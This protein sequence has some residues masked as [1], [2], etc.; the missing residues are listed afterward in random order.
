MSIVTRKYRPMA[1]E[2]INTSYR[3]MEGQG[4]IYQD[5]PH[6]PVYVGGIFAVHIALA[7]IPTAH[8]LQDRIHG[9]AVLVWLGALLSARALPPSLFLCRP[10]YTAVLLF[11]GWF[12]NVEQ[13]S[14]RSKALLNCACCQYHQLLRSVLF[15]LPWAGTRKRPKLG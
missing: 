7:Y 10:S 6:I 9:E 14:F 3:P 11:C 4:L 5:R 13:T 1:W 8:L 15:R 12:N 2:A